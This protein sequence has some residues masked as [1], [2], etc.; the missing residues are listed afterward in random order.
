MMTLLTFL[1]TLIINLTFLVHNT[2]YQVH[3]QQLIR[4]EYSIEEA[5][6]A[7]T[8]YEEQEEFAEGRKIFNYPEGIKAAN[9]I[10]IEKQRFDASTLE[11]TWD[12][13]TRTYAA[14][15]KPLPNSYWQDT[16]HYSIEFFDDSNATYPF[17]Y[18]KG[19]LAVAIG[20]P[21]AVINIG[22]G[23]PNYRLLSTDGVNSQ[24]GAAYTWEVR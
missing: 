19:N 4:L 14:S 16:V 1:A 20:D 7:S 18:N 10:L 2:D 5:V 8:L 17:L 12:Y 22:A 6:A 13:A 11:A 15:I 21:T 24:R 3:A 23:K 9:H